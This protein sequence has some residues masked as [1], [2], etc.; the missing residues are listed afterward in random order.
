MM[1]RNSPVGIY[2]VAT[3]LRREG[4]TVEL[5]NMYPLYR[6]RKHMEFREDGMYFKGIPVSQFAGF[7]KCGNFEN[8]NLC[9][10]FHRLGLPLS[11]LEKKLDEFQPDKIFVGNTFTFL[12]RAVYEIVAECKRVMP[13]V[14][15]K[16][17]GLY[18]MLCPEH[19]RASGADEVMTPEEKTVSD[20]F[21]KIDVDFFGDNMPERI[22]LGTS[23]GCPNNC[24]YCAVHIV[25]GCTKV[26]TNPDEVVNELKYYKSMGITKFIFL[27]ANILYGY[28][29]H[30]EVI[31]DKVIREN[32][33]IELFSYG[34]VEARLLTDEIAE[35]MVKAGFASVNIPIESAS[36]I[37]IKEW[38]RNCFV[39]HWERAMNVAKRHF[40]RLR[41]FLIIGAPN[42]T[43]AD[44]SMTINLIKSYGA[45]AVTLPYTPIPGTPDY[46]KYKHIDL[47]DLNPAFYPCAHEKMK[48]EDLEKF[49]SANRNVNYCL[50]D[51]DEVQSEKAPS[52]KRMLESSPAIIKK[53]ED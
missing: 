39:A 35:K 20:N 4:H 27:D 16:V 6:P 32:L 48:A 13:K 43:T 8:E 46:E 29:K 5:F 3:K 44:I 18:A 49:Y 2:K 28:K 42:Q 1:Y 12:W 24:S 33:N 31:L 14:P 38:K 37:I 21:I 36:D 34:G 10:E 23:V 17:G 50:R 45:E 52:E 9:R 25:E 30:F 11:E 15:V 47:E 40:K 22:F 26:N 7:K 51:W 41:S 53:K 19:A